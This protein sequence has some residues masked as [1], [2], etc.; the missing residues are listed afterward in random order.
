[1]WGAVLYVLGIIFVG[2]MFGL[3]FRL[4][5]KESHVWMYRPIMS[6]LSTLVLSWLIFYSALTIRK[7]VWH[8][9]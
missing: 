3:A 4:E 5:T 2:F 9:R 8:R 1:M 7:M 6:L